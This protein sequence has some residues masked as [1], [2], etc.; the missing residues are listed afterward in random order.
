[1]QLSIINRN[2][3]LDSKIPPYSQPCASRT[4]TTRVILSGTKYSRRTCLNR[5]IPFPPPCHPERSRGIRLNS[6]A[7]G[8]IPIVYQLKLSVINNWL[9]NTCNTLGNFIIN[10]FIPVKS[11]RV[12]FKNCNIMNII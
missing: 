11:L 6:I 10:N 1:M 3:P 4:Q 5:K 9:T 2:G 8:D 12:C 7:V